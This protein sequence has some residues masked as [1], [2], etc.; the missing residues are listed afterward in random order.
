VFSRHNKENLKSGQLGLTLVELM[1][2]LVVISL[3]VLAVYQMF[4]TGTELI[5]EQYYRQYALERAQ[6]WMERMHYYETEFDTV[7]REYAGTYIDT[8]FRES[9]EH[10][11]ILARCTVEIEH[12]DEADPIY[13]VPYYSWV[14]VLYE[15]SAPSGRE[16]DIELQSKF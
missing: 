2:A 9:D 13:G 8:L 11:G 14:R 12:S 3:S 16:Y 7:P 1:I 6:A 10:V 5:S 15:W 4:V